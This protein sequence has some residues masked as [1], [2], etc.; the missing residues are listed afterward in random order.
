MS[1]LMVEDDEFKAQD[2]SKVI[3]EVLHGIIVQRANSVTSALK[4]ISQ[5][6]FRCVILDMS[7]P[8]FALSGPGGGGSP[9]SQGGLEVLRLARRLSNKSTFII[10]TQYPDIEIDGRDVSLLLAPA[11]LSARFSLD[12]K[13]CLLYEFDGYAWRNPLRECLTA[14]IGKS[15]V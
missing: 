11:A 10:V 2:I 8:T 9:Q 1:V 13:A 6:D 7:L 15:E 14:I 12:V 5:S 4:E 3:D